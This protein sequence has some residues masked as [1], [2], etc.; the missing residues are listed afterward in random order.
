MTARVDTRPASAPVIGEL[1]ILRMVCGITQR[2]L[3][4]ILG[5]NR[6]AVLDWEG[7]RHDPRTGQT[8]AWAEALDA[9]L[10][11]VAA[12]NMPV[13]DLGTTPTVEL[14]RLHDLAGEELHR[15]VSEGNLDV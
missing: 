12:G 10:T 6:S 14:Q 8:A 7:G 15:R 9:R 4:H 3:A 11:L 2:R 5:V 1:R 13:I